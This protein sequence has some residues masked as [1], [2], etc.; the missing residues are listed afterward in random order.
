MKYMTLLVRALTQNFSPMVALWNVVPNFICGH[1]LQRGCLHLLF[2]P[3]VSLSFPY[4]ALTRGFLRFGGWRYATRGSFSSAP[5]SRGEA[6]M[7]H[8]WSWRM[9]IRLEKL[10]WKPTTR[11]VTCSLSL[12]L[13]FLSKASLENSLALS[14]CCC[15]ASSLYPLLTRYVLSSSIH[16]S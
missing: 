14:I 3:Y 10:G 15:I 11:G 5:L 8:W 13:S 1:V 12:V 6:L 4:V 2:P 16:H 9:Y 7:M